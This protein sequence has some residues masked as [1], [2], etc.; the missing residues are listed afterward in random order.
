MYLST[1]RPG[2]LRGV[3]SSRPLERRTA[4][5]ITDPDHL[6]DELGKT[7]GRHYATD[8]EEF[9]IGMIAVAVPVLDKQK[10]LMATLSVH[11]PVQRQSLAKLIGFL[12][13]LQ[14]AADKLARLHQI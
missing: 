9:M 5:T 11:A 7:R 12:P 14:T 10:R 2:T 4:Q 3:L 8:A 6:L 1:L 13:V